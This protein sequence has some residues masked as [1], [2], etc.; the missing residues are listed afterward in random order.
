MPRDLSAGMLA[1]L[2]G[3]QIVPAFLAQIQFHSESVFVWTGVGNLAFNGNTYL[4]VGDFGQISPIVEGTDVQ[5]YGMSIGLSGID[6]TLLS[7]CLDDIQLGAPVTIFLAFLDQQTGAILG[8]PFPA[9]VGTVDQ[10][11][12]TVGM[13]T[14]SITLA[15]EN[16]LSDLMRAN[17]R[18]YTRAD[19]LQAFPGDQIFFAV[20]Y[21]NDLAL[22]WAA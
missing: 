3:N 11:S 15:L 8:T 21:L 4:G 17:M 14:L 20:C 18:R 19:Q 9:F 22:H 7:E 16:K 13:D 2:T 10:P 5:A 6:N 1:P 12:I